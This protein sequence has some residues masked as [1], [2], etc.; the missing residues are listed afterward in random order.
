MRQVT[1][2]TGGGISLSPRSGEDRRLSRYVRLVADE[3]MGI[4]DGAV[5]TGCIDT[6]TPENWTDCAL[7]QEVIDEPA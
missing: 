2:Y 1:L 7:P 3:G 6:L 5:I 4:T